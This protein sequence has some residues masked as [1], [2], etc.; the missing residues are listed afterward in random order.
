MTRTMT[1]T[2]ENGRR[3]ALRRRL[4]VGAV[5]AVGWVLV[6]IVLGLT[7]P[8][9]RNPPC[10]RLGVGE[11][12]V[13]RDGRLAM[14]LEHQECDHGWIFVETLSRLVAWRVVSPNTR[15][16]LAAWESAGDADGVTVAWTGDAAVR[17]ALT[18]WSGARLDPAPVA[19]VELTVVLAAPPHDGGQRSLGP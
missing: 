4:A 13:S 17:L 2:S 5:C 18:P 15:H 9:T 19:G 1:P 11:T 3:A 6:G 10:A 12:M 14:R 16:T 8:W 7:R